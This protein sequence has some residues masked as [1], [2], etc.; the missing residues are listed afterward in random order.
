MTHMKNGLD[1]FMILVLARIQNNYWFRGLGDI[2]LM[3]LFFFFLAQYTTL[4]HQSRDRILKA[5]Q[6]T[7]ANQIINL[8]K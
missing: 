6:K 5:R 1:L 2:T 4:L 3:Q 8:I 7:L